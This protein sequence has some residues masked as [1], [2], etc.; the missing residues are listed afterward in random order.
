[1]VISRDVTFNETEFY[2]DLKQQGGESMDRVSEE[3]IELEVENEDR[4]P[5]ESEEVFDQPALEPDVQQETYNLARDRQRRDIRPPTRY[6]Y[7]DLIAFAFCTAEE[8]EEPTSYEQPMSSLEKESWRQA[9]N[10]EM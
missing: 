7:S 3:E 6:G 1:M 4:Q 2:K 5:S 9:M 8:L 10:E